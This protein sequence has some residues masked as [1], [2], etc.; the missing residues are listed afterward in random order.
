MSIKRG[1]IYWVD[2]NPSRGSEQKGIRPALVIQNDIGNDKSATTIVASC[3]T[4]PNKPYPFIVNFTSADS[5]LDKDGSVDLASIITIDK[6][7]LLNKLG[8]LSQSKMKEVDRALIISL[9][10]SG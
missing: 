7:R 5:G 1:D 2:W 4:A 6:T 3:T 9:G 10:I 8:Q